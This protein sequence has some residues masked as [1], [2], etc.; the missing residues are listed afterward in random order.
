MK[1]TKI[2]SKNGNEYTFYRIDNDQN[3]NPRYVIHFLDMLTAEERDALTIAAQYDL[4]LARLAGYGR[5]YHNKKFGGGVSLHSYSLYDTAEYLDTRR[6]ALPLST[7]PQFNAL[8][9]DIY[10][11]LLENITTEPG[12][13][14]NIRHYIADPEITV[15]W[16]TVRHAGTKFIWYGS[17]LTGYAQV[18]AL[19]TRCGYNCD[20]WSDDRVYKKYCEAADV[21]LHWIDRNFKYSAI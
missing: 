10:G 1:T 15:T 20:K 17:L 11:D 4:V 16:G 21:V 9:S 13:I 7:S 18:R 6:A 5:R 2:T 19:L 3:G 8:L 12:Y 14:D